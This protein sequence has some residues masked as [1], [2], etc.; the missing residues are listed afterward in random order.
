[1][2][3][4]LLVTN[5][6]RSTWV[7]TVRDAVSNSGQ[8]RLV[9]EGRALTEME[10]AVYDIVLIDTTAVDNIVFLV[11]SLH[12]KRPEAKII[13]GTL[14]NDWQPAREV[15]RAGATDYIPKSLSSKELASTLA[16]YLENASSVSKVSYSGKDIR[17]PKGTLLFA[18]NDPFFLATRKESLEQAGYTVITATNPDD[19]KRKLEIGGIDL[20]ILDIR[21][22][23]DDDN[24][25]LS[26]LALAKKVGRS[27]PKIILTNYPTSD[28]VR[29]A[30]RPQ[31]DGLP[32]A[33]DF[34]SKAEDVTSLVMAIEDV[35]RSIPSQRQGLRPAPKVFIAHGHDNATRE[36]VATFLLSIG[37]KPIVLFDEVDGGDTIIEKL[38]RCCREAA[39][40]F[41]LLT[42]DD[43]GYP[44]ENP[45][46]IKSRARQNVI[47]ELGYLV[48]RLG[49]RRVRVLYQQ[50]VE[51]PTNFL[52]VV[53]INMDDAGKW[54]S[55][56]TRE[57]K[58]AGIPM[59]SGVTA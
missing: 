56:L 9:S 35:L 20:A 25:D 42:P 2:A 43:Y 57:L 46:A 28:Y 37:I 39:F 27:V 5:K 33:V 29:E 47:F 49:R 58:D 18:D 15:L 26:G 17:S 51:I 23:E 55:Y 19:A 36:T 52:G 13:V 40:A 38:E 3:Q 1:M 45:T 30:L 16:G 12:A 7:K 48:A 6:T 21:L 31:L 54:R 53:Y 4:F 34:L 59:A 14:S 41:I 11:A 32:V 24:K 50:G 10:H 44:K 8:L 22:E